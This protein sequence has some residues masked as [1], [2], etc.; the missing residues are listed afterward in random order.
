M[1]F[2]IVEWVVIVVATL[3]ELRAAAFC[4]GADEAA[5]ASFVLDA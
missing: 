2:V 1:V 3:S 5:P 4:G